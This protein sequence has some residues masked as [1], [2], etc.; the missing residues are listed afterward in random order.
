MSHARATQSELRLTGAGDE[1]V[2][3]IR[4]NGV[5]F[6]AQKV[7]SARTE[8]HVGLQLLAGLA[9]QAEEPTVS[10]A[11]A[12]E[13]TVTLPAEMTRASPGPLNGRGTM[14]SSS[15]AWCRDTGPNP[16]PWAHTWLPSLSEFLTTTTGYLPHRAE[17]G[18]QTGDGR[19]GLYAGFCAFAE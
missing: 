15:Q 16:Y 10:T 5:G 17:R 12:P 9:P 3:E 1:V 7:A 6:N 4:D 18:R 13:R 11:P 2:L 8:G 19:V 14:S